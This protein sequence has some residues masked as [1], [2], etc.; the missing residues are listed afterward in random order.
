VG[1]AGSFA[2]LFS[3]Q[4]FGQELWQGSLEGTCNFFPDS[5]IDG[6]IYTFSNN[7]Q[8]VSIV[9]AI[10]KASGL[11]QNF[12]IMQA[13][14]P[15]AAAVIRDG[16]R[17]ILY[18]QIFI[19]DINRNTATEWASKTILA[20]EVGHHLNGHT[21]SGRGSQPPTELEADYYAGYVI[22]RLG[23]PMEGALAPFKMMGEAGS[24]THP[25]RAA[26]LEA[27]AGGWH[28]ATSRGGREGD[29]RTQPEPPP[30]Q[31]LPPPAAD[32]TAILRDILT[33]IQ[34]GGFPTKY[35]FSPPL[36]AE[37]ARTHMMMVQGLRVRGRIMSI[38]I[39]GS[40]LLPHGGTY[41]SALVSFENGT[42]NWQMT[43]EPNG[44]I[45]GL[46]GI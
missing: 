33:T 1:A 13:S 44:M 35:N 10:V 16:Q 3:G 7:Q 42:M 37:I 20:H 19:D 41:L 31:P 6:D 38:N 30:D 43:V 34:Q 15:N 21:L 45:S 29:G 40:Q 46:Y 2:C 32:S 28:E 9:D 14:V 27:V 18:S 36:Q 12:Q 8:A 25:P 24:A 26:R 39:Q 17:Y 23:G 4:S 5:N 22:G 11:R